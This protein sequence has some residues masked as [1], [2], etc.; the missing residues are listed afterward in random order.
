MIYF[1]FTII[2]L[3]CFAGILFP[4]IKGVNRG[5]FIAATI[6]VAFLYG[7][8]TS[9][10]EE[11]KKDRTISENNTEFSNKVQVTPNSNDKKVESSPWVYS[12]GKDEMRGTTSYF[13]SITSLNNVYFPF[14]YDTSY[15]HVM[16]RRRPKDGLNILFSVDSGQILC[17]SFSRSFFSVKFDDKP[18][19]KFKCS[20]SDSGRSDISFIESATSFLKQIKNSKKMIIEAPFYESGNQQFT[21]NTK[22]L[23][24]D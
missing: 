24:F 4:Y 23:K 6:G 3:L 20:S 7:T 18:I 12:E 16:I 11:Q 17:H 8:F 9:N 10:K 1:I 5:H 13:A 22:D 21:F 19:Q 14:P 15:A 2:I